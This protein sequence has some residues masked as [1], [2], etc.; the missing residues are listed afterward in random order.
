MLTFLPPSE[1]ALC[2]YFC[3]Q[4][5]QYFFKVLMGHIGFLNIYDFTDNCCYS[6]FFIH[7][8]NIIIE[9]AKW[10]SLQLTK[11]VILGFS[12]YTT[13]SLECLLEGVENDREHYV[14]VI[15]PHSAGI[16]FRRQNRSPHCK[17][18]SIHYTLWPPWFIQN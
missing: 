12:W 1:N 4:S 14:W 16:D 2:S 17:N 8:R 18:T 5:I 3:L 6:I 11:P 13:T 10:Y 9:Y 7:H 15:I